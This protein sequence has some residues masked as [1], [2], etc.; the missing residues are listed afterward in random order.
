MNPVDY[1]RDINAKAA[2][3]ADREQAH[4]EQLKAIQ[5]M[6]TTFATAIKALIRYMDGT[7]TKTEV[8]NQLKEIGTPDAL[9]VVDAVKDLHTT[10]KTHE[11]TDLTEVTN[12]LKGVLEEVSSIPKEHAESVEEVTVK[13]LDTLHAK[14]DS[15]SEAIDKLELHVEAPVINVPET[16][17]KVDA[18][19]VNVEAPDFTTLH[20]SL[21]DVVTAVKNI[22]IPEVP[23]TDLTKVEKKLDKSNELLE[24]ISKI[25][26]S[27]GGGGSGTSFVDDTG[28]LVYVTLQ[29]GAVPIT[30]SITATSSTLA[31]FSVNDIEEAT[32][33]YFGYTKPDGTWLVKSLTDTSVSYATVTNNGSVTTYTDAW[34]DRAILIYGRFDEAF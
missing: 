27:S 29:S 20:K 13:N 22:V 12:L 26:G 10:L 16:Q 23:K 2:E 4:K 3:K 32:T 18:P 8:V 15:I 25:R 34:T 24:E 7:T 30:G 11:N 1:L 5:N 6:E 21:K 33:S 14:F 28:S 19:V 17:V 31:D 9:K